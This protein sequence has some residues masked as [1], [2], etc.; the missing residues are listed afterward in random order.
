MTD[1]YRHPVTCGF[2]SV[3][4]SQSPLR[5]EGPAL[6]PFLKSSHLLTHYPLPLMN[7]LLGM[8]KKVGLAMERYTSIVRIDVRKTKG[9]EKREN[10]RERAERKEAS[11]ELLDY[12]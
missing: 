9:K 1:M 11:L 2:A 12:G 8:L 4:D 6:I 7:R 10:R 3:N 5:S